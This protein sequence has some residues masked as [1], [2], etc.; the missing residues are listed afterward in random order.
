MKIRSILLA[1]ML[2]VVHAVMIATPAQAA[3][4]VKIYRVYFDSPGSDRGSNRSL[5]AEYITLKNTASTKRSLKGWT[6]RD[7]SRHIY[8]FGTYTL[9]PGRY[10]TIH[11]GRGDTTHRHRYWQR[12]WYVWNNGGDTATLRRADGTRA[13]RCSWD[14]R[15]SYKYC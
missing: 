5:N 2:A 3:S 1:C 7:R 6:V 11:T 8:R 13:D 15:G 14:S 4:P 9:G 10:V 12:S